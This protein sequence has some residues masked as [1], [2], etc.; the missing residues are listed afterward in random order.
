MTALAESSLLHC[1]LVLPIKACS[2]GRCGR[3][4][5]R[6]NLPLLLPHP[7]W[8]HR[9]RTLLGTNEDARRTLHLWA[10]EDAVLLGTQY[11][12]IFGFTG[13]ATDFAGVVTRSWGVEERKDVVETPDR[14]AEGTMGRILSSNSSLSS[15]NRVETVLVHILLGKVPKEGQKQESS[16]EQVMPLCSPRAAA[17]TTTR[18]SLLLSAIQGATQRLPSLRRIVVAEYHRDACPTFYSCDQQW[19]GC[20]CLP[21]PEALGQHVATI[22]NEVTSNDATGDDTTKEEEEVYTADTMEARDRSWRMTRHAFSGGAAV[23]GTGEDSKAI[24]HPKR[25]VFI[26]IVRGNRE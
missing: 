5:A 23:Q 14:D 1:S 3:G 24:W 7:L 13:L 15:R 19:K 11:D 2:L 26:E 8:E 25:N 21:S 4:A 16:D 12:E 17:A 6:L 20:G 22:L 10:P 18:L 9:A